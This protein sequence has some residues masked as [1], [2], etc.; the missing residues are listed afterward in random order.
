VFVIGRG[1]QILT[2]WLSI[3]RFI[4]TKHDFFVPSCLQ[5][6]NHA[7]VKIGPNL[8]SWCCTTSSNTSFH[9]S[10]KQ[11]F[12]SA[13]KRYYVFCRK[14]SCRIP[15]CGTIHLS[16][17][18]ETT[19]CPKP[20]CRTYYKLSKLQISFLQLG[21][22]HQNVAPMKQLNYDAFPVVIRDIF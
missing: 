16:N 9:C 4:Y 7:T 1:T 17:F 6:T 8:V 10:C 11:A 20:I 2:P 15:N 5:D 21:F 3:V 13:I 22:R 14:P 19:N 18:G 12:R